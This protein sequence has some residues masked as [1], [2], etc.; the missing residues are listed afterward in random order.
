MSLSA[1]AKF[2]RLL[3]E[4]EFHRLGGTRTLK[5]NIRVVAATNR[6][7][8]ASVERGT[9]REDLFYRL[10]V[11]DIQIAPLR[12]RRADI[13]P[14]SEAFLQDIGKSFGRPPGGLTADAREAMLRYDWPGNVRELHNAHVRRFYARAA[15]SMRSNSP[16]TAAAARLSSPSAI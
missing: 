13:L 9:F 4:H 2:L 5:A 11:F 14:L 12:E 1:Q 3:Q 10:Q 16:F 7:L 15:S 6:D 8:R